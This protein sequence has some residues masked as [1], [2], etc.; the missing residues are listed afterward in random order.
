[1]VNNVAVMASLNRWARED[2]RICPDVSACRYYDA[3]N[4]TGILAG[5]HCMMSYVG[6]K[7]GGAGS[8][9]LAVVGMDHGDPKMGDFEDRRSGIESWYQNGGVGF[10]PHYAGVVKTAAAVLGEDHCG[11]K[12]E[13]SCQKAHDPSS[14]CVLD[15]IAQPNVVKCVP[16]DVGNRTSRTNDTMWANCAHHLIDELVTL[17]P[18]LIVFHGV[19]ARRF[20]PLAIDETEHGALGPIRGIDDHHGTVL[21]E[22]PAL[23]THL[24]FLLHPS[25]GWLDR[26]WDTVAV[27]ALNYLRAKGHIPA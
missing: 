24:L 2:A 19:K 17:R 11:R 23:S 1:M 3:C 9:R 27:P 7:Y 10:N 5:K 8:F 13:R 25:R 14:P 21:Y 6:I 16:D 18:Q 12:C 20:V 15:R 22:W 26:Q 4:A